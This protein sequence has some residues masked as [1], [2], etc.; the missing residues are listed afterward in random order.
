MPSPLATRS[1]LPSASASTPTLP[2]GQGVPQQ[3]VRPLDRGWEVDRSILA[4]LRARPSHQEIELSERDFI[5]LSRTLR[6]L[7]RTRRIVPYGYR[8]A[9]ALVPATRPANAPRTDTRTGR[10]CF[11]QLT[12]RTRLFHDSV[13]RFLLVNDGVAL[14]RTSCGRSGAENEDGP[15]AG[16]V[17]SCSLRNVGWYVQCSCGGSLAVTLSC[18]SPLECFGYRLESPWLRSGVSGISGARDLPDPRR[19]PAPYT[20]RGRFGQR[21]A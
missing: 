6:Q 7:A 15:V 18:N 20:T 12:R 11:R 9:T 4:L 1:G 16:I 14:T 21:N 17:G 3:P 19:R 10:D 5:L 2:V 13:G 8:Y